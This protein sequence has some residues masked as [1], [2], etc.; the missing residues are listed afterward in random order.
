MLPHLQVGYYHLLRK[1]ASSY[2]LHKDERRVYTYSAR[3]F[4]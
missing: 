1:H 2:M 4:L 3:A